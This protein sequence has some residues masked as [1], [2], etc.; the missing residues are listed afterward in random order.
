MLTITMGQ[1][2]AINVVAYVNMK[3]LVMTGKVHKLPGAVFSTCQ[4]LSSFLKK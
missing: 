3:H 2:S 1:L 4:S